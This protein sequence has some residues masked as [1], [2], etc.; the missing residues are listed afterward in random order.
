MDSISTPTPAPSQEL[1][2]RATSC[3]RCGAATSFIK[4]GL[5]WLPTIPNRHC[6]ACSPIVEAEERRLAAAKRADMLLGRA[7]GGKMRD[8]TLA[9]FP[10]DDEA[11]AVKRRAIEWVAT[12]QRIDEE[13]G[14]PHVHGANLI[15]FGPVGTGKTGLA[16]SL[17][18]AFCDK[19]V[20]ARL[21]NFR[22]YLWSVRQS[23]RENEPQDTRPHSVPVLALDDLGAERATDFARDELATLVEQRHK[24]NLPTIITSN[25]EPGD[26]AAR[27]GH[28]EPV[29]GQRIV[30]RL[31]ERAVQ[32]RFTGIDR[33]LAA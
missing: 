22:D 33:R 23:F 24:Q 9:T 25:Y 5:S 11:L 32:V 19:G 13:E 15:L 16:W 21:L 31:T 10:K 26:L 3:G 8:W 14:V 30:S 1:V 2:V 28:D 12:L 20:E 17:V 29:I 6:D 4:T 7:G 27:L 18:R